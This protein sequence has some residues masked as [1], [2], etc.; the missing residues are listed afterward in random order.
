MTTYGDNPFQPGMVQDEYVPDQLIAGDL[1]VVTQP[2]TLIGGAALKRGTVLGKTTTQNVVGIAGANT[3]NGTIGSLTAGSGVKVGTYN[4]VATSATN[5]TVTD[6]EGTALS[7][8]TVGTAYSNSGLGFTITAGGTAFVAGDSFEVEVE[9]SVGQYKKSV[10]SANDGSQNPCAILVDDADATGG[11]VEAGGYFMGEFN[12]NRLI[13]DASWTLPTLRAAMA[14]GIF[15][16][17]AVS[18]ADPS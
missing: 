1:K 17:S 12:W 5:F 13:A 18:A 15:I 7:A 8:A 16:K 14:A 3:G 2:I 11:P 4:L 10:S 9:D 6:P